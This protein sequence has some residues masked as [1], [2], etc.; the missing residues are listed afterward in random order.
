MKTVEF[1]TLHVNHLSNENVRGLVGKSC[2]LAEA[3]AATLGE[4]PKSILTE[5]REKFTLFSSQVNRELKR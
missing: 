5:L 4:L 3:V 1:S 2:D